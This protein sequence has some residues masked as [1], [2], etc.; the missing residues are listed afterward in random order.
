M[1]VSQYLKNGGRRVIRHYDGY[2]V[3]G[4]EFDEDGP[5]RPQAT[6]QP[7]KRS[8]LS[9]L[10]GGPKTLTREAE[11]MHDLKLSQRGR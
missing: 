10:F 5:E 2:S 4:H 7:K 11:L 9:I 6:P 3:L 1:A 8:W